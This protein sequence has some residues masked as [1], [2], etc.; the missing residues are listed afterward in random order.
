MSSQHK[1]VMVDEILEVL[2]LRPGDVV[3]DGTLGLGG[4]SEQFLLAVGPTGTLVGL[5]WDDSMRLRA[6]ER[7]REIPGTQWLLHRD[8]REIA[9]VMQE[10]GLHA[11]GIL[12]DLGLNSAQVDDPERGLSF[13]EEGPLDMR[14][15][16]SRGEP[17][18]ALLNRLAPSEIEK[19]LF[20]YADERWAKAIAKQV[21][22]RRRK[23]PLRTTSDLV[24]C[25]LAAIPPGARDKRIH[26]ATRTFQAVRIAINGE[27]DGLEE[28]LYDAV[29]VLSPGGTLAVLSYHSGEDRIVKSVARDLAGEGCTDLFRK[30]KAPSAEEI[31]RN[32]RSRSAKLRAIRKGA[33]ND[34]QGS[35]TVTDDQDSSDL[36]LIEGDSA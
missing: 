1:P 13:R 36:S 14:M 15:D 34:L 19:I 24:E 21:L 3:V 30:P 32:A 10:L 11:R 2:D 16:R 25:V 17:A 7:L 4:H 31:A 27:L 35:E 12:L 26:P 33:E 5:D 18:S 20:E 6:Q 22:E 29:S 23:Q 9:S 28:A 8:F